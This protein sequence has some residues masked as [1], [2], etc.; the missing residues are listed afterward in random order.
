MIDI[1]S[2][3]ISMA[4]IFDSSFSTRHNYAIKIVIENREEG[5]VWDSI[6]AINITIIYKKYNLC[7]IHSFYSTFNT[8]DDRSSESYDHCKYDV[9]S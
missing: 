5:I 9:V 8:C 7:S 4:S 6:A 1:R 3:L 2:V